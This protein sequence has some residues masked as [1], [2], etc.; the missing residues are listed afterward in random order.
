MDPK[1]A[2]FIEGHEGRKLTVYRCPAGFPTFGVGRNIKANPL[3]VDEVT[4]A[5]NE[6]PQAAASLCFAHDLAR[7]NTEATACIGQHFA[8]WPPARKAAVMSMLFNLGLQGFLGFRKFL[9]ALR[10]GRWDDAADEALDSERARQ[11]PRR[12]AEEAQMISS[13][14]WPS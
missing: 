1:I 10:Y 11:L 9:E 4:C 13:G 8:G 12:S 2:Q 6:G 7:V 14:A 5:I 3:T